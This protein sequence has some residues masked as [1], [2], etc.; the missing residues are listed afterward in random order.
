MAAR[1]VATANVGTAW[2]ARSAK[3][4]TASSPTSGGTSQ[5]V[6]LAT[7]SR[8]TA[9]RDD[10]EAGTG[11]Q[12]RLDERRGRVDH[13]L[14]VVEHDECAIGA[15]RVDQQIDR[16]HPRPLVD[17]QRACDLLRDEIAGRHRREIDPAEAIVRARGA[18]GDFT[19]E[20]GLAA[21]AGAG[22][23]EEPGVRQQ[24]IQLG[25]LAIPPDESGEMHRQFE[26]T[27]VYE[28]GVSRV[29][30]CQEQG[31]DSAG[32]REYSLPFTGSSL[33]RAYVRRL[34]V[35]VSAPPLGFRIQRVASAR[36]AR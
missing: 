33:A 36:I 12:Q 23:G 26:A 28:T 1:L 15:Q 19:C 31:P 35:E 8:F 30:M 9:G 32:E 20:P 16:A 21:A 22:E 18:H 17:V 10:G 11:A 29:V 2:R 5:A 24:L 14:A 25:Q 6:A 3:S 27:P 4:C 13:V 7:P 34:S